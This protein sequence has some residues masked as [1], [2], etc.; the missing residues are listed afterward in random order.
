MVST[1]VS[2][3][4]CLK[5]ISTVRLYFNE[6][7]T[8]H[9]QYIDNTSTMHQQCINNASL[10]NHLII[11]CYFVANFF[12]TFVLFSLSDNLC[13]SCQTFFI[14]HSVKHSFFV[15]LSNVL[16]LSFCQTF[17]VILT[18]VL[19]LFTLINIALL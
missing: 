10:I 2:E 19:Y 17:F 3:V 11:T 13:H 9:Q 7:K 15:N 8:L 1:Y 4:K 5:I 18:N 14:C 12:F 6:H 16:S